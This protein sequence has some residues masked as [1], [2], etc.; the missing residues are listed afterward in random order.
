MQINHKA[1]HEELRTAIGELGSAVAQ[2][3]SEINSRL[4]D[5]QQKAADSAVDFSTEIDAIRE[6]TGRVRGIIQQSS[7]TGS[8]T[9]GA[10]AAGSVAAGSDQESTLPIDTPRPG[11]AAQGGESDLPAQPVSD[12]SG[13]AETSLEDTQS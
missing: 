6:I 5:L 9:T 7:D 12:D 8:A 11:D 4:E 2:E 10:S 13:T 1:Q 3:M